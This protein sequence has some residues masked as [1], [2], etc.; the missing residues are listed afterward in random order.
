V[1]CPNCGHTGRTED[2]INGC[3]ECGYA[4]NGSS[5]TSGA[6]SNAQNN[7]T[8]NIKYKK[9][10]LYIPMGSKK[11]KSTSDSSLPVWIYAGCLLVLGSLVMILYSCL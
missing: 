1:L 3:P 11:S 7:K 10:R 9:N 5:G 4:V 2:F 6:K 8:K